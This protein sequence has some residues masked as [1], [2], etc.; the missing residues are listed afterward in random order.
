MRRAIAERTGD[1]PG[2]PR[3]P[4]GV[5]A[6]RGPRRGPR[7]RPPCYPPVRDATPTAFAGTSARR[8]SPAPPPHPRRHRRRHAQRCLHRWRGVDATP[9]VAASLAPFPPSPSPSA[10]TAPSAAPTDAPTPVP[11]PTEIATT[12]PDASPANAVDACTGTEDNLG[13]LRRS[14]GEPRLA[15]LLPGPARPLV[16]HDRQLQRTGDRPAHDHVPRPGRRDAVAAPGRVLRR[17]RRLCRRPG[18]IPATRRS[19]TRAARW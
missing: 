2:R 9:S 3:R 4:G 15:G 6:P 14:R 18:P 5:R 12:S 16:G 10:S 1:R 8:P 13:V 19:A 17:R 7:R 11:T